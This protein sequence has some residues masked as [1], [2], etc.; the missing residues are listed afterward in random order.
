M[1]D[2]EAKKVKNRMK[3]NQERQREIEPR[4]GI[5]RDRWDILLCLIIV[6]FICV[7]CVYIVS[8]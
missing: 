5:E 3:S 2:K 1:R 8:E 7:L 6:C 4:G